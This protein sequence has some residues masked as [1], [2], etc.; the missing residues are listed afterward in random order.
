VLAAQVRDIVEKT[1]LGIGPED[2]WA[3]GEEHSYNMDVRWSGSGD[4]ATLDVV[5]RKADGI[6]VYPEDDIPARAWTEYANTPQQKQ[7]ISQKQG[8]QLRRF[9]EGKLPDYMI[10]SAIVVL[11][12]LPRTPNGKV[13]RKALPVP[14]FEAAV[15]QDSFIA[16]TNDTEAKLAEIWSQILGLEK[17]GIKDDIFDLGGDSILIFQIVTRANQ[18]GLKLTPAQLF[19]HRTISEL[20]KDLEGQKQT[21]A[22]AQAP[23]S[24]IPVS[25][26]GRQRR[27]VR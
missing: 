17:V 5:F 27:M 3:I 7:E 20:A 2:L 10:P 24:I 1:P 23:D 19:R 8:P 13:D 22:R 9:L 21:E 4:Q 16:P 14:D 12:A 6:S 26:E 25:R 15:D 11:D 18:A